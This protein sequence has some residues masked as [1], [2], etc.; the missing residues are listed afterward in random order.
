M[1]YITDSTNYVDL[2]EFDKIH[3][4]I[5]YGIAKAEAHA[6]IGNLD[7]SSNC[8]VETSDFKPL[9]VSFEEYNNLHRYD[10]LYINGQE[11]SSNELAIYLKYAMQGYDLYTTYHR[12]LFNEYFPSLDNWLKSLDIFTDISDAYIMC[13]TAGGISFEHAHPAAEQQSE[14]IYIRP[15]IYRPFYVRCPHTNKKQYINTRVAYWNDQ[16]IH[17]GDPIMQNTYALRVDGRF[18]K[19]FKEKI[20]R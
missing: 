6:K 16:L 11:L 15:K 10:P 13:M 14:F 19:E 2:A 7:I 1:N 9:C 3:L 20:H 18:T 17:G 4:E 8:L 5:C 12:H